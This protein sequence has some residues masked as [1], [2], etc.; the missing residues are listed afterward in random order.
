M[1]DM[2][3][4][5][6]LNSY[7]PLRSNT[8]TGP[9]SLPL[10]VYGLEQ[11]FF[12]KKANINISTWGFKERKFITSAYQRST[13]T[14]VAVDPINKRGW[15]WVVFVIVLNIATDL[16]VFKRTLYFLP[17]IYFCNFVKYCSSLY[18]FWLRNYLYMLKVVNNT[19]R[20]KKNVYS[21]Y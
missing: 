7:S 15:T 16:H 17:T 8:A 9:T 20:C 5:R 4:C 11:L 21:R 6:Q 19:T 13:R 14:D 3:N 2:T 10:R 12:P 18:I 1:L